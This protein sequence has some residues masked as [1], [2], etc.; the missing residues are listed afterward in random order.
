MERLLGMI[1]KKAPIPRRLRKPINVK[2][3][4][5]VQLNSDSFTKGATGTLSLKKNKT[6]SL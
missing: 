1:I 3:M 4:E 6:L 5:G 2:V